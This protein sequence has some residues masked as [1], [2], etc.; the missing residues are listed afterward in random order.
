MSLVAAAK[1]FAVVTTAMADGRIAV[2]DSKYYFN[3]WRP[4]TAIPLGNG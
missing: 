2:W 4:V 3:A 1:T